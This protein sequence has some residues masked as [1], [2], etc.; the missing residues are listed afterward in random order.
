[1]IDNSEIYTHST[2]EEE[3][4]TSFEVT[5][6]PRESERYTVQFQ[7]ADSSIEDSEL[8]V[9]AESTDNQVFGSDSV[10]VSV[11]EQDLSEQMAEPES[12]PGIQMIQI[13]FVAL[14]GAVTVFVYS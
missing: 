14:L 3:S 4:G 6:D 13:M 10:E 5:L 2:L 9:E 1:M 8:L 11:V 12:I 7:G